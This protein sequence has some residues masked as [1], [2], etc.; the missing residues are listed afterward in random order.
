MDVMSGTINW[1][2]YLE[3]DTSYILGMILLQ[4]FC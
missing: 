3:L 4:L 2:N 1:D